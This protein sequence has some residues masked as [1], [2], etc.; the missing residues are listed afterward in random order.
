[1]LPTGIHFGTYAGEAKILKTRR[2]GLW[3]AALVAGLIALPLAS[4]P[5]LLGVMTHMFIT[6]MAVYGLYV[7]VGMAGQINIAQSA[8]VGIGAFTAAKLSGYGLPVWVIV[9]AAAL[10]TGAISVLFALPAAR[11]KGFYLAL[12]TLAAQ[13]MFPIVILALPMDWL[14]GLVGLSVE[15]VRLGGLTLTTPLHYYYF[16]LVLAAVLTV[17]AFNLQRSRFGRSL[18][19]VRD[20]DVVAEV[21]GIPVFRTKILAFFAGSLFAGVAGACTA[22]V[23]Q[24]V[25][26]SS[27]TLF[28]SVW[29]LGMLIVGGAHSALGAVLGVVFITL[30]QE[31]LHGV[32]NK[33][34]QAGAATS[35]GMLFALTSIAL[36]GC[37]LIALIFEPRGL[38]HRWH[39]LR[40][41]FQLWPFPRS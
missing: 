6:L 19:A 20:N 27:F 32:A 35:G 16:T 23:L 5:Y 39:V 18:M 37:I 29:Y 24:F 14:G 25:T 22:Y 15:P 34:V 7:T 2:A 38:A 41:A 33:V 31:G 26:V 1:M 11:V 28:A 10:V 21:M 36:G 4:G 17:A 40:T 8:F 9:P 12:T 13:V 30:V 3:A